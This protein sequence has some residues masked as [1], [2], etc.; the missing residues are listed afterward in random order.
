LIDQLVG[1]RGHRPPSEAPDSEPE[2]FGE[3]LARNLRSHRMTQRQL[4]DRAG[5]DHSTIS[6]LL[7]GHRMPSLQ[8]AL[9]LA[10]GVGS[11]PWP[12]TL[13]GV[14]GDAIW[15]RPGDVERA[16]RSDPALTDADVSNL[17]ELYLAARR[18]HLAGGPSGEGARSASRDRGV[19]AVVGVARTASAVAQTPARPSIRRL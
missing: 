8:T 4:A 7:R 14:S 18:G 6:R 1:S 9:L 5:V 3:W 2:R 19:P 17:M 10:G 15:S 11:T 16:F 13:A 12:A